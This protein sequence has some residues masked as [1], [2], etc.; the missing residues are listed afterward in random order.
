MYKKYYNDDLRVLGVATAFEDFDKNTLENLK[1]LLTTGEVIG[2]PRRVL[3]EYGRLA[4]GNKIGHK[5]PFPVAMDTLLKVGPLTD[6]NIMDFIEANFPYFRFYVAMLNSLKDILM[7]RFIWIEI[8]LDI[9]SAGVLY[10]N[11]QTT[12]PQN[13]QINGPK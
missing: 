1:L 4:S 9:Q 10:P 5:I 3:G 12:R 13:L 8:E 2:A 7:F 6:D 11:P